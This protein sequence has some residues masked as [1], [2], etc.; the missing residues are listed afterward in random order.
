LACSAG[1][2]SVLADGLA[3]GAGDADASA[4][5]DGFS[6]PDNAISPTRNPA[7]K[8]SGRRGAFVSVPPSRNNRD[9]RAG[10]ANINT[11][12]SGV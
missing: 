9:V 5:P 11:F 4:S 10:I 2:A 7:T 1:F 12:S 6:H 8:H 3:T